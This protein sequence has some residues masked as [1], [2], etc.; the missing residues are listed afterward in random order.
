MQIKMKKL[1]TGAILAACA[2]ALM[3]QT[4]HAYSYTMVN[5]SGATINRVY[6][7]TLTAFCKNKNWTGSLATNNTE[8][9]DAQGGCLVDNWEAWDT[10][11]KHYGLSVPVGRMSETLT[12]KSD[13][14]I[15]IQ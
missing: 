13:G 4:V 9:I 11:G 3:V 15:S 6:M 8:T 2:A 5:Q 14:T 7:H 1:V 12:I 10:T